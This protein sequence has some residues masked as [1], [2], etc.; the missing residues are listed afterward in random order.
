MWSFESQKEIFKKGYKKPDCLIYVCFL[1]LK[2]LIAIF[3]CLVILSF[4]LIFSLIKEEQDYIDMTHA[5][6]KDPSLQIFSKNL[7]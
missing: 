5:I 3:V 1:I 4:F 7:N 2:R 6:A